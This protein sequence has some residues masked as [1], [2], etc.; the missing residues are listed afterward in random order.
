MAAF[1]PN[2]LEV[3]RNKEDKKFHLE[4]F[5]ALAESQQNDQIKQKLKEYIDRNREDDD[6]T[7]ENDDEI[8]LPEMTVLGHSGFLP[9][10]IENK[11]AEYGIDAKAVISHDG[12]RAYQLKGLT[13][14]GSRED[15][16]RIMQNRPMVW[17]LCS[18]STRMYAS[19]E[20]ECIRRD[21][22]DVIDWKETLEEFDHYQNAMRYHKSI[23]RLAIRDMATLGFPNNRRMFHKQSED[24]I[25]RFLL[26]MDTKKSE[27]NK[28]KD[29]LDTCTRLPEQ[30][31]RKAF[32]V[33]ANNY[34]Q[35]RQMPQTADNKQQPDRSYDVGNEHYDHQYHLFCPQTVSSFCSKNVVS[36]LKNC[37]ET[38]KIKG[39][40]V[41]FTEILKIIATM[42]AK[43]YNDR[44]IQTQKLVWNEVPL[45]SA[46]TNN[47][48]C[49]NV[50]LSNESKDKFRN[51]QRMQNGL[52]EAQFELRDSVED[53]ICDSFSRLSKE[54]NADLSVLIDQNQAYGA[55]PKQV[56]TTSSANQPSIRSAGTAELN[57]ASASKQSLQDNNDARYDI[58]YQ[59]LKDIG[60]TPVTTS[61]TKAKV[62]QL[63]IDLYHALDKN[64]QKAIS[65][66]ET[67]DILSCLYSASEL[68]EK[69]D[70]TQQI[71]NMLG[72]KRPVL[73]TD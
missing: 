36:Y 73:P 29:V 30:T 16:N 23:R 12:S 34:K 37:I 60:F 31:L 4:L 47:V 49:N 19:S 43:P 51:E 28:Y 3:I 2:H 63:G 13:A 7:E 61:Q 11:A 65:N 48:R 9:Y 41:R 55:R 66:E 25:R 21:A 42:E 35:Y 10:E 39:R 62:Q 14:N 18:S 22:G 67:I 17:E 27:R 20:Q 46:K 38:Q 24:E 57:T 70:K 53:E 8:D 50:K 45:Q 44:P 68:L 15:Y 26:S 72:N 40:E 71:D 32:T 59:Q 54:K 64:A 6:E 56:Q 58:L 69:M 52:A 5:S 33:T 1:T